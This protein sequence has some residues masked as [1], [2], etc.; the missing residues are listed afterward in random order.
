MKTIRIDDDVWNE[1]AKRGNFGEKEND[2]LR[3]EFNLNHIDTSKTSFGK[4]KTIKRMRADVLNGELIVNFDD[5]LSKKWLLPRPDDKMNFRKIR[6]DAI[7][8]VRKN[9]GTDGQVA[10]LVKALNS[11]GYYLTK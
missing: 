5:G 6:G 4:R 2:V 11:S 9:D 8:F 10:A 1:I 3:R 7:E